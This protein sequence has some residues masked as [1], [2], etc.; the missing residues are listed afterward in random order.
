ME[1]TPLVHFKRLAGENMSEYD[2]RVIEFQKQRAQSALDFKRIVQHK[3][4][5]SNGTEI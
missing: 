1:E 2:Y 5:L 3:R 4:V